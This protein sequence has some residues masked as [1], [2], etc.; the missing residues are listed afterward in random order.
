VH[1]DARGQQVG[2]TLLKN[3]LSQ[4]AESGKRP[5]VSTVTGPSNYAML[6]LLLSQGFLVRTIMKDYFGAG[7]DR[8]YCQYKVRT[9]YLDPDD[10]YLIPV[11]A[12]D[13]IARLMAT[14][15][16]VIT[17]VVTLPAGPDFEIRRFE[18]DDFAALQSDECAASITFAAGALGA[19]TFIL[20]FSF[21]SSN[22]PDDV[23][24]LLIGAAV[25]TTFSLIIY[26]NASGEL[27]RLRSNVFNHHMKWGN[28][29]SE[30]GGVLPFLVTLPVTLANVTRNPWVGLTTA[31]MVSLALYMYERSR[32]AIASRFQRTPFI[33][34]LEIATCSAPITGALTVLYFS[35]TWPWTAAIG[36]ALMLKVVIYLIRRPAESA[37]STTNE[38]WAIR[39]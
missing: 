19:I 39:E 21:I 8:F 20:G 2:R 6:R 23:R 33:I 31:A 16:R 9:E 34:G 5:A 38:R 37:R 17:S 25:I 28:V 4:I 11:H 1:P 30:Y 12:T 26:A 18:R 27:S 14:E 36:L 10:R 22:Y 29:L 24:V 7:R 35:I 13:H 32:F 3:L 15:E